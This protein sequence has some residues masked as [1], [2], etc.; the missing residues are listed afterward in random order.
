[1]S[2]KWSVN[3]VAYMFNAYCICH[4]STVAII[5]RTA[6]ITDQNMPTIVQVTS[7]NKI[8]ASSNLNRLPRARNFLN[9]TGG[10]PNY[11]SHDHDRKGGRALSY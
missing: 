2:T 4:T 6:V 3:Y 1:M 10:V 9:D 7:C 5:T 8:I 11:E